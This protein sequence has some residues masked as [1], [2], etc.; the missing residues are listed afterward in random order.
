MISSC[1]GFLLGSKGEGFNDLHDTSAFS[2]YHGWG[3]I[4]GGDANGK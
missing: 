1:G 3:L 2:L 4:G